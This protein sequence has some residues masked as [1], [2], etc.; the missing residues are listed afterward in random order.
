ME[1]T[2][3][4]RGGIAAISNL[5]EQVSLPVILKET[6]SGMSEA[7]LK[8][9]SHLPIHAVDVSGLGGTHWGRIEGMRAGDGTIASTLG[10]T[11]GE[12]GVPTAESISNSVA[13]LGSRGVKIW[14]SGGIRSGLD[15]AKCLALGASAT[16]FARP[17]L[18]SALAGEAALEQ[19]MGRMEQ[20]LR[21]ALFCTNS[22][23]V[24]ELGPEKIE[25]Q[26]PHEQRTV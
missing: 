10:K 4:F 13:T 11:F 22:A 12:W 26:A 20:E 17:A 14:A 6:G 25:R 5:I 19:W 23:G 18:A 8:R 15:A 7:F 24:R 1:G 2:R 16:G 3:D 9:I 21:I